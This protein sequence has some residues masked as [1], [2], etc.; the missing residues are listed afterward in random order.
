MGV[1]YTNC[2]P[3]DLGRLLQSYREQLK[4]VQ[5]ELG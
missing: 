4:E 5:T 3:G 2:Y 1:A